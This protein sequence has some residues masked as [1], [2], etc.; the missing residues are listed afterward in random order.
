MSYCSKDENIPLSQSSY[1]WGWSYPQIA[2][3]AHAP[4]RLIVSKPWVSHSQPWFSHSHCAHI[5]T[6]RSHMLSI[7]DTWG[8]IQ[9][10][11]KSCFAIV[12]IGFCSVSL[13][14]MH[15][16]LVPQKIKQSYTKNY[17]ALIY[18]INQ[19]RQYFS[20]RGFVPNRLMTACLIATDD[21]YIHHQ[22]HQSI[23]PL[24]RLSASL[25]LTYL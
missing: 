16:H 1:K 9:H 11:F 4:Y 12:T 14:R 24:N 7:V 5:I 13:T 17:D 15:W 25:I 21:V 6:K 20:Q 2:M 8:R 10:F 22:C 3:H 18:N 19:T 23:F